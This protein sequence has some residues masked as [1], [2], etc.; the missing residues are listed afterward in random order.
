MVEV[1]VVV[2]LIG[3]L[4]AI[5]VPKFLATSGIS[6]LDADANRLRLLFQEARSKAVASGVM[7]FV[8]VNSSNGAFGLYRDDLD[9]APDAD[10]IQVKTD[11]LGSSV[12]YGFGSNWSAVP[13]ASPAGVT[14]FSATTVPSAGLAPGM[15]A[16]SGTE[17]AADPASAGTWADNVINF[18]PGVLGDVETGALYMT[19]TRSQAKA[20]AILYNDQGAE[21]GLQI[22]RYVLQGS[23]WTQN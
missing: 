18:C 11:T 12:R 19:T 1:M 6:Q 9:N 23:T 14:G 13:S 16:S 10:D 22:R 20:Y 7:H 3:I 17:C 4:S 5:A 2:V 15:A 21:G 8:K